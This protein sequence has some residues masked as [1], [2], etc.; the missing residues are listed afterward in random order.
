M[1]IF[2]QVESTAMLWLPLAESH[3]H[4]A[5]L[6]AQ[7]VAPPV[8]GLHHIIQDASYHFVR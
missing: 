3:R 1:P 8:A 7:P 5:A 2:V 6:A 4:R